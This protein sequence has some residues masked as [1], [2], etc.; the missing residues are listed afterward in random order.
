LGSR[1]RSDISEAALVTVLELLDIIGVSDDAN[2]AGACIDYLRANCTP[3]VFLTTFAQRL[4]SRKVQAA[5]G[6]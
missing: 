6:R 4:N 5:Q 3:N 1:S 2:P